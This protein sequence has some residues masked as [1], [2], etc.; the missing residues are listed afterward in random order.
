MYKL[1]IGNVRVTVVDDEITRDQATTLAKQAIAEA[2]SQSKQL[3]HVELEV[4]S[5]GI[6]VKATE[7]TGY[8]RMRKNIKQSMLDCILASVQEKLNPSGN[9]TARDSWYDPDTGQE[10]RGVE[11]ETARSEITAKFENWIK[12]L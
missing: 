9:F 1:I 11:V 4:G 6:H 5:E 10:W 3:S 12:S 7:K 8:K 2:H